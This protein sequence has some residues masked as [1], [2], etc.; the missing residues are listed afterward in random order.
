MLCGCSKEQS[1]MQVGRCCVA[2]AKN[3]HSCRLVDVVWLQQKQS[4][5]QVG[6]CC[7]AAAKTVIPTGR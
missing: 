3:S 4:F 7:V 1:F 2:A 6:R 5:M